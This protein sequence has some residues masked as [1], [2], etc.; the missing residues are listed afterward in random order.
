MNGTADGGP[1][2]G[3][4]RRFLDKIDDRIS[5]PIDDDA[6]GF[7]VTVIA[8][9]RTHRYR[10]DAGWDRRQ[11]FGECFGDGPCHMCGGVG[12]VTVHVDSPL[13]ELR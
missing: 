1:R 10:D 9:T 13:G 8:G 5:N 7:S 2:R 11:L 12:V 4:F 3:V 6:R